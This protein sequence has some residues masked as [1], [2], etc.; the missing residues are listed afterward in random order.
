MTRI[1]VCD[2]EAETIDKICEEK[3]ITP[4]TLIRALLDAVEA[5]DIEIDDYI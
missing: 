5:G 4:D 1:T 2:T 3:D